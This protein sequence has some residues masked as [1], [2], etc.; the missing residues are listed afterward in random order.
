MKETYTRANSWFIQKFVLSVNSFGAFTSASTS[1]TWRLIFGKDT[2]DYKKQTERHKSHEKHA[3][4]SHVHT[5]ISKPIPIRS[6]LIRTTFHG[7]LFKTQIERTP[8]IAF[9][10]TLNGSAPKSFFTLSISWGLMWIQI[11]NILDTQVWTCHYLRQCYL[12]QQQVLMA[13]KLH[14][15]MLLPGSLWLDKVYVSLSQH[16]IIYI[17]ND[18]ISP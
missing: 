9:W 5:W 11:G 17:Y 16:P 6:T 14:I 8:L 10:S 4:Y 3:P 7:Q 1:N 18:C 2:S 13:V 15:T 12:M